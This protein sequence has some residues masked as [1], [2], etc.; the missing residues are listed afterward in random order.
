MHPE[1]VKYHLLPEANKLHAPSDIRN[2]R[3]VNRFPLMLHIYFIQAL[4]N[5]ALFFN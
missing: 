1:P 2:A 5:I 3:S 4:F